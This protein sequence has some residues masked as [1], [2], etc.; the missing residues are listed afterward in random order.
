MQT[1]KKGD[2]CT[3]CANFLLSD[4]GNIKI[5][6][7]DVRGEQGIKHTFIF[8]CARYSTVIEH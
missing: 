1:Q 4:I 8:K 7:K 6:T 2:V 3:F 5:T